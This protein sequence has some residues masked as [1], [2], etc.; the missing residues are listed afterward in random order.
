[1]LN[2]TEL[3]A[4]LGVDESLKYWDKTSLRAAFS[5]ISYGEMKEVA[6]D[7]L[8]SMPQPI[9]QVC[10]PISTGGYGSIER[11]IE[12]FSK[13][14]LKL[15]SNGEVVFNQMPF[16]VPMQDLK[17]RGNLPETQAQVLLLHGFYAPVF[18]SG[19]VKK[20]HFIQGWESSFGAN[21]EHQQAKRL[22]IEISYL[23]KGFHTK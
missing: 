12:A 18:E 20:L 11:N 8:R 4:R 2:L 6:L 19:L 7:I 15:T 3:E 13:T 23:K 5:S 9:S 21:W 10:G 16:E 1:M 22:G 14:I 17:G